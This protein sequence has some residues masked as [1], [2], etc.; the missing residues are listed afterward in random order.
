MASKVF[1]VMDKQVTK[2]SQDV[3]LKILTTY[4][5][6]KVRFHLKSDSYVVQSFASAEVW[7][8]AMMKWNE[9]ARLRGEEM[10][11]PKGLCYLPSN[12]GVNEVHFKTDLDRLEKMVKAVLN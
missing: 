10:A 11:T 4:G 6:D 7:S 8:T 5:T 12:G 9:V 2:G 3:T 1:K